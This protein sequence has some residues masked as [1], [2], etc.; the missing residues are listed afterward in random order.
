M[1]KII[2]LIGKRFGRLVVLSN[3]GRRSKDNG[4]IWDCLC[5]CGNEKAIMGSH[6]R[7]GKIQ[8][9][10]CLRLERLVAVSITHGLSRK[11]NGGIASEYMIWRSMKA[12]CSNPKNR[13]YKYYGGRGITVCEKWLNDFK[14]FFEDMGP[15]PKGL[16]IDRVDNDGNY[17]PSN[18]RWA[19]ASQQAFNRRPNLKGEEQ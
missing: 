8:S 11:P 4:V 14:A 2:D 17:E 16:S 10:G 7:S 6:L 13:N 19:T 15:K 3:S 5:D 12:R 9:C 1:G 18:C